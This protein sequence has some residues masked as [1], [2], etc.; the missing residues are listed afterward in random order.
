[1]HAN[2]TC[3]G[4]DFA[5]GLKVLEAWYDDAV[6]REGLIGHYAIRCLNFGRVVHGVPICVSVRPYM[7]L[8]LS[9]DVALE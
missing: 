1:M 2:N 8:K 6:A 4:A 7:S 3:F 9:V 5:E